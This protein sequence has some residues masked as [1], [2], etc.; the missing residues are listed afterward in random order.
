M[1]SGEIDQFNFDLERALEEAFGFDECEVRIDG[2]SSSRRTYSPRQSV[3]LRLPLVHDNQQVGCVIA[4]REGGELCEQDRDLLSQILSVAVDR[5]DFMRLRETRQS[6]T[7]NFDAGETGYSR[8]EADELQSLLRA[9]RAVARQDE[10]VDIFTAIVQELQFILNPLT[11]N[12]YELDHRRN[13]LINYLAGTGDHRLLNTSEEVPADVGLLGSALSEGRATLVNDAHQDPP[14][15]YPS[16]IDR[17]V[18]LF[19]ENV[20]IAPLTSGGQVSGAIAVNRPGHRRFSDRDFQL[21]NL[22]AGQMEAAFDEVRRGDRERANQESLE[23]LSSF[24]TRIAGVESEPE[25][26]RCLVEVVREFTSADCISVMVVD[27][28]GD[29]ALV[30]TNLRDDIATVYEPRDREIQQAA[31]RNG[32]HGSVIERPEDLCPELAKSLTRMRSRATAAMLAS[33]C[34]CRSATD[35]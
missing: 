14:S 33:T 29:R 26:L 27:R 23:T 32:I 4:S 30:A 18:R 19:G 31:V 7:H 2:I 24:A 3:V 16:K 1:M 17:L 15:A 6:Q 8:S 28:S 22:F 35:G 21:F 10:S 5:V 12:V 25:F 34:R 13:M 20:M 9:Q 11:V